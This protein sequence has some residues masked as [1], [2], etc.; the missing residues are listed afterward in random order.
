MKQI[1]YLIIALLLITNSLALSIQPAQNKVE[2][3]AG[4]TIEGQFKVTG[5]FEIQ[6]NIETKIINNTVYYTL[7]LPN[8]EINESYIETINVI[9]K[10]NSTK[11]FLIGSKLS[12][13]YK[14][15]ISPL[16]N[17]LTLNQKINSDELILEINNKGIEKTIQPI[18]KINNQTITFPKT[19]IKTG[20]TILKK[21]IEINKGEYN[22]TTKIQNK[23]YKNNLIIGRPI[24][25]L[26]YKKRIIQKQIIPFEIKLSSDWNLPLNITSN[27]TIYNK[28]ELKHSD[29]ILEKNNKL[30]FYLK[31]YDPNTYK[32]KLNIKHNYGGFTKT[33]DL[34]IVNKT[35][36]FLNI[37]LVILVMILPL[38]IIKSIHHRPKNK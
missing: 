2:F 37:I 24:I 33:F 20:I 22:I 8:K 30:I 32:I 3:I 7:T 16:K 26:N 25:T 29:I 10:I 5:D 17:Y 12:L 36:L 28:E 6:S 38:T 23:T 14:I 15:I 34:K 19:R 35:K 4:K 18:S 11:N 21:K 1:L 27:L 9:T 13:P 31:D